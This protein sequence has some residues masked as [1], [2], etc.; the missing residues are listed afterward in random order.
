MTSLRVLDRLHAI[1]TFVCALLLGSCTTAFERADR[2]EDVGLASARLQDLSAWLQGAVDRHEIPGAVVL[3]ARHGSIA[4]FEAFGFRDREVAA[5]MERDAIFRIASMTKPI[6]SVAA[7]MLVEQG[8]LD[9]SAPLSRYLPEFK[10]VVVGVE[11]VQVGTPE[12]ELVPAQREITIRDLLR[13]T[14][15]L[16][17]GFI[18]RSMVKDRYNAANLYDPTLSLAEV[19]AR[20]ARLPLQDQPGTTW[21][22]SVS[23]DV[24]GRVIEVASGMAF[25][26]FL[27][28]RIFAPLGMKDTAFVLTNRAQLAR[29]AQPQVSIASG[30]RPRLPDP[31]QAGWPSGGGGLVSTAVDYARFCQMLL[32]GGHFGGRHLLSAS[33]VAQMMSD[34]L[35]PGIRVNASPFPVTDVR[36]ENGQSFGLGFA[37]RVADGRSRFPGTIGDASWTGG[38]GTQ[39]WIDPKQRLFAILLM[40]LAPLSPG[41]VAAVTHFLRMREEV[42]AA[43]SG[44]N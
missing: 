34:Q 25:D 9:L 3:I 8:R 7:M 31:A 39:F 40:Q 37:I 44:A 38:F 15:G 36:R 5:V 24:L 1:S 29:L 26:R 2:P 16:T 17:Y 28:E 4:Y 42:Y 22:Y 35:P 30:S 6:T 13:H 18:G 19:T 43:L 14:S 33:S 12:L 23:T 20:I 32:N 21:N 10:D 11:P 41:N 27:S